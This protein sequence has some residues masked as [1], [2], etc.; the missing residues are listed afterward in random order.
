MHPLRK[1]GQWRIFS[2]PGGHPALRKW[3]APGIIA[4]M[5]LVAVL[6]IVMAALCAFAGLSNFLIYI[7]RRDQAVNLSFPIMCF[8]MAIYD[9]LCAGLYGSASIT[10]GVRWQRAQIVAIALCC[11]ALLNFIADYTGKVPRAVR[12]LFTSWFLV[13]AAAGVFGGV[14]VVLDATTPLVKSVHPFTRGVITYYEAAPGLIANLQAVAGL[15]LVVYACICCVRFLLTGP[16]SRAIPMLVVVVLLLAAAANDTLVS[17]G[18]LD[19]VYLIEYSFMAMV[20]LMSYSIT[21]QVIEAAGTRDALVASEDK[22][23]TLVENQGEGVT[24]VDSEERF[25]FANPAADA[26][27]GV[28]PGTLAGRF[29]TDFLDDEQRSILLDQTERRRRGEKSKYE[30]LIRSADGRK[31]IVIVTATPQFGPSGEFRGT[32]GIFR[33]ETEQRILE[34]RLRQAQKMEAVGRFAGGIA[35]DFNNVITIIN[36]Y[37][38]I[39]RDS[40]R[41]GS[42]LWTPLERIREAAGRAGSVTRQLLAFS[43]RQDLPRMPTDLNALLRDLEDPLRRL[44]GE[45]VTIKVERGADTGAILADKGQIEQIILNLAANARD[46][47]PGGGT[48]TLRTSTMR[49]DGPEPGAGPRRLPAGPYVVLTVRDTGVGMGP[50]VIG[51]LFEPFFTTKAPGKGTGLG[52]AMAYGIVVQSKGDIVVDSAP[53]R[54]T[55][56]TISLPRVDAISAPPDTAARGPAPGGC[57]SILVVEDEEGVR[58]LTCAI[59]RLLG[60]T[61]FETSTGEEALAFLEDRSRKVDLVLSDVVMPVIGGPEVTQKAVALRPGVKTMLMSGYPDGG[62]AGETGMVPGSAFLRKPFTRDSLAR[63]VREALDGA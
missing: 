22:Y 29:F 46:A 35:H 19:F 21:R 10:D 34:E 14:G 54:G 60:Y 53:G 1:P 52:L 18:A 3:P 48:L 2:A 32:F 63:K 40:V 42:A 36:G 30:L 25:L 17:N 13:E 16:R 51:H 41:P 59:L 27:L 57:E 6:P 58:R 44:I 28:P 45:D 20:L 56:V 50:E 49:V 15:L 47:M 23:R 39:M 11:A 26:I 12:I 62:P 55:S 7:R 24:I 31:K 61:V 4:E 5:R 33:D 9:L 38:E 37:T 43:R 8:L